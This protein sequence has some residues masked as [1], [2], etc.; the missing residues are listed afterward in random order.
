MTPLAAAMRYAGQ[1]GWPVYPRPGGR[2]ISSEEGGRG[3]KDA[4]IDPDQ[5]TQWWTRYPQALIA[6][7]TGTPSG[8]VVLDIDRKHG[9]DGFATLEA[10]GRGLL[11]TTPMVHTPHGGLHVYFAVNPHVSIGFTQGKRGVGEGLDVLGE[12]AN[13]ALPTPG[14][15]YRWDPQHHPGNTSLLVAPGWFARRRQLPGDRRH[16]QSRLDPAE[17]LARACK[18]IRD[19]G[20]GVRHDV[21][22]REAFIIGCVVARGALDEANARHELEAATTAMSWGS[23]R[24]VKKAGRDLADA[25]KSGLRKGHR[26]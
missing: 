16:D 17:L 19:A 26:R 6:M 20:P 18:K 12:L 13:V 23:A 11:P 15:G 14:W 8:V 25:F 4:T 1:L 21:L 22:N 5:I 24:D 9:K 10:L 2:F 3:W 7:P